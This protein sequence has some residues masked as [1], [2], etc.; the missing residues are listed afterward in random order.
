MKLR[1]F[2]SLPEAAEFLERNRAIKEKY[3]QTTAKEAAAAWQ[4]DWEHKPTNRAWCNALSRKW[5]KGAGWGGK[6]PG[7]GPKKK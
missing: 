3:M 1:Q 7:A 2:A 4:I 5:P 6:R